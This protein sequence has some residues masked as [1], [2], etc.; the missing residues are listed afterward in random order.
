MSS[1]P[2]AWPE[3]E[4]APV[5]ET[6]PA[7]W[8]PAV[9]LAFRFVFLYFVLL[10][11]FDLL[12]T[13][14][15]VD[16]TASRLFHLPTPLDRAMTGSGDKAVHWVTAF[17][18]LV[19][20]VI[21]TAVWSATSHRRSHRTLHALLRVVVR[22]FLAGILL[23]YGFAKVFPS[24]FLSPG[25]ERLLQPLGEFS[26]M[27]LLWAFMGY[28]APYTIFT[29]LAEVAGA[30]LL[31]F[32]RTTTLGA[33]V[34]AGIMTNV[35]VMNLAYDVAVKLF[36]PQLLLWCVFLLAPDSRRLL[37]V[38]ILNRTADPVVLREPLPWP[39]LERARKVL[40]PIVVAAL[41]VPQAVVGWNMYAEWGA[42]APK[43]ALFGAYDV[44][45]FTWNGETRPPLTTDSVRWRRVA[46]TSWKGVF[47]RRMDESQAFYR[48][49]EG[50]GNT[51]RLSLDSPQQKW[52][53][54]LAWSR[55]DPAHVVLKG[56]LGDDD[57][58]VRL[59]VIDEGRFL[60]LTRGFRWVTESPFNR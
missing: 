25:P 27:G 8:T 12:P 15:L 1:L 17:C 18:R 29:G 6:R 2:A 32:R 7:E 4:S 24:Q 37:N 59:R 57:L 40:K 34:L 19:L 48:V 23:G 16:W 20:G 13:A 5:P 33:L 45:E 21:G 11:T 50:A 35:V 46:V 36:S 53:A 38:F 44:E 54:T 42:A 47:V 3:P 22:Y 52:A 10:V 26:P 14:G 31:F 55:P 56:K 60:L 51:V 41:I 30:V 9:R 39:R 28:S 43:P 58:D 49:E